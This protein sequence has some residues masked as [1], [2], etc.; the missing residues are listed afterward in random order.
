MKMDE[1]NQALADK[2][3][4]VSIE[5]HELHMWS[6][7]HLNLD[8]KYDFLGE[9]PLYKLIYAL[10]K[11]FA[12]LVFS[13]LD[14]LLLGFRISGREHIR[15]LRG[16]GAI[17]LCN[18]VHPL[19]CTMVGCAY[20]DRVQYFVTLQSNLEIPFIR[21]LVKGLGGIPIPR[22]Y[23]KMPAF[24]QAV[25]KALKQGQVVQ[26][27]PEGVLRFYYPGI[28][29]FKNGAFVYA[30]D[31]NVPL[32]PSVITY[33]NPAGLLR[34]IKRKPCLHMTVLPPVYPDITRNKREEV[35]RL[36]RLCYQQMKDFYDQHET[37]VRQQCRD[38]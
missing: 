11:P 36:K 1:Y 18:H 15:N 20:Y 38:E 21:H 5:E 22:S 34:F 16:Q 26:I 24:S 28:R 31:N 6:P 17:S 3:E 29:K 27:Y 23:Q 9:H 32:I 25:G 30:Y 2:E 7:L 10:L 33:D 35:E 4:P 37:D 13:I 19:D 12:V 14:P 8:E